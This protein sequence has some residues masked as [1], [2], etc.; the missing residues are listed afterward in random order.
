MH[1]IRDIVARHRAGSSFTRASADAN[2]LFAPLAGT[3]V[4]FETGPKAKDFIADVKA[5]KIEPAGEGEGGFAKY[6]ITL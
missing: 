6:L 5:L 3:T 4:L 1:P 2:W